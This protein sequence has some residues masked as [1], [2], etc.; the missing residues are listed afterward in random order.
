MWNHPAR[1]SLRVVTYLATPVILLVAL[2][3]QSA[4]VPNAEHL[5]K[6]PLA[7]NSLQHE[8]SPVTPVPDATTAREFQAVT[9]RT[10]ELGLEEMPAYWHLLR[11]TEQESFESLRGQP[12]TPAN[13]ASLLQTP[14]A[15]RGNLMQMELNVRRI[16]AYEVPERPLRTKRLY[17]VWGWS[18][19][20]PENLFVIVTP[21]LPP[22]MSIGPTV[23]ERAEFRGYFF[24]LQG[25]LAAGAEIRLAPLAAPLLI[26]RIIPSVPPKLAFAQGKDWW[27]LG[28]GL[29]LVVS[30]VGSW[31]SRSYLSN[32]TNSPIGPTDPAETLLFEA[33]LQEGEEEEGFNRGVAEGV[34]R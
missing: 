7:A 6:P 3:W 22:G 19:D 2:S 28:V 31:A 13:L 26:G 10:T 14:A 25:Y 8:A 4:E 9:D 34:S 12:T 5:A 18:D 24:K 23:H 1:N 29:I 27:R 11:K 17:E 33:W 16:L 20:A 21:E 15:F 30:L 32:T